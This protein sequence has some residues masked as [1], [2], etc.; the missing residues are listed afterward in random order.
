MRARHDQEQPRPVEKN[1]LA[2][3]IR[4]KIRFDRPGF[5]VGVYGATGWD[6]GLGAHPAPKSTDS[7]PRNTTLVENL[8]FVAG[9]VGRWPLN[10]SMRP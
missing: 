9:S 4:W 10:S 1:N 8:Y 7:P 5:R 2:L 3:E 6:S